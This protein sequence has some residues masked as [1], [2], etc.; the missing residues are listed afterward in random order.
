MYDRLRQR[1]RSSI[2]VCVTPLQSLMVDQCERFSQVGL[3]VEF[4]AAKTT[5]MR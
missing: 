5:G 1:E 4:V 3:R 2:V